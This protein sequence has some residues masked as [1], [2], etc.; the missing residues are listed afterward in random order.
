MFIV[1]VSSSVFYMQ[2]NP[3]WILRAHVTYFV[4]FICH[5]SQWK[6]AILYFNCTSQSVKLCILEE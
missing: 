6:L 5:V 1:C 2:I 3:T 4:I